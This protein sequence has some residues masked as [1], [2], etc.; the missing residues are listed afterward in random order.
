MTEFLTWIYNSIQRL[1]SPYTRKLSRW[2]KKRAKLLTRNCQA[3]QFSA[4]EF[5]REKG[6]DAIF[7]GH[8][9]V[10]TLL[11][12]DDVV[13]GNDGTWQS[14]DPHFIGIKDSTIYLCKF[15]DS[16]PQIVHSEDL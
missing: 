12:V 4:V 14:D 2:L 13:Y 10:A 8:T 11:R 15:A 3:I 6:I 1:N 5:A 16:I 9:H 7:C